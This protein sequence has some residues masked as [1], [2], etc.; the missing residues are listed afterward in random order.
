[1]G[2][3][4]AHWLTRQA[5]GLR[6][7]VKSDDAKSAYWENYQARREHHQPW[8]E[9]IIR[10]QFRRERIAILKAVESGANPLSALSVIDENVQRW[11]DLLWDLYMRVGDDFA[12]RTDESLDKPKGMLA[13]RTKVYTGS[14]WLEGMQRYIIDH[15]LDGAVDITGTTKDRLKETLLEG[16]DKNETIDQI[17][18]RIAKEFEGFDLNRA[19]LIARTEIIAASNAGSQAAARAKGFPLEKEWVSTPDERTRSWHSAVNGQKRPIDEPYVVRGEYLMFPG[20]DSLGA[21]ADNVVQCRC[22][23]VYSAV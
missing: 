7:S 17:A 3:T 18:K 20:D 21:S 9:K 19:R 22:V 6:A 2:Q 16:I 12:R 8:A 13:F 10:A 11:K 15:A 1:M 23:E 14:P 5:V 4:L